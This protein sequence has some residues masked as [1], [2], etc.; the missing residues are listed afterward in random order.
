MLAHKTTIEYSTNNNNNSLTFLITGLKPDVA[1][2]RKKLLHSLSVHVTHQMNI[3]ASVRPS[4]LGK[5]GATLKD[6]TMRTLTSIQIP[7]YDPNTD[8]DDIDIVISITGDLEAIQLAKAE[9]DEIVAQKTKNHYVRILIDKSFH[10]FIAGPNKSQTNLLQLEYNIKIHIP[11]FDLDASVKGS[12]EI[13]LVGERLNVLNCQ[14]HILQLYADLQ[15]STRTVNLTVPKKQH[16]LVI[17]PKAVHLQEIL[18]KTGC[19][20]DIPTLADP[21][22]SIFIRGPEN[23]LSL[24]LQLVL[25]KAN[26][27]I[28]GEL[29]L[30]TVIPATLDAQLFARYMFTKE[31]HL[32]KQIETD[33]SCSIFQQSSVAGPIIEL[34]AKNQSNF[35][36]AKKSL[37]VL[38]REKSQSILI[39]VVDIPV[40]LH[41]FIVGKGGQNIVK[42]KSLPEWQNKLLDIIVPSENEEST[43]V[44]LIVSRAHG[45]SSDKEAFE[46]LERIRQHILDETALS[47]DFVSSTVK[48]DKKYHGRLIGTG[49]NALKELLAPYD[50][51]VS[52]RFPVLNNAD[53]N[54]DVDSVTVK[55]PKDNVKL[56]IDKI[57]TM[58]K[59]WTALDAII[60][61]TEVLSVP[62]GYGKKLVGGRDNGWII[63]QIK[64]LYTTKQLK[65]QPADTVFIKDLESNNGN[66]YLIFDINSDQTD[67]ITIKGP[68]SFLAATKK[69]LEAKL[70][71]LLDT[72]ELE[73]NIFNEMSTSAQAELSKMNTEMKSKLIKYLI[74]KEGKSLRKI[75]DDHQ[76]RVHFS[77]QDEH[78]VDEDTIGNVNI[79]GNKS[80]VQAVK[81]VFIQIIEEK[82]NNS[83]I[84]EMSVPKICLAQIVGRGG[85]N[86]A[87]LNET[88]KVRIDFGDDLDDDN[89]QCTIEG[90]EAGCLQV[91]AILNDII[92]DIAETDDF[93]IHIPY[94]LHRLVI[95]PGGSTI[96][97]VIEQFGGADKVRI[98]FPK[99]DAHQHSTAV[100]ITT[101][102]TDLE[103]IKKSLL[104]LVKQL[105]VGTS[106]KSKFVE[107]V[108]GNAD[109]VDHFSVPKNEA[110]FV[111]GRNLESLVEWMNVYGVSLWMDDATS[112]AVHIRILAKQ[113]LADQVS[114]LKLAISSKLRVTVVVPFPDDVM[115]VLIKKD[116]N[117]EVMIESIKGMIKKLSYGGV[118]VT[119]GANAFDGEH[120]GT[121]SIRGEKVKVDAVIKN[122]HKQFKELTK[123][124]FQ[125]RLSVPDDMSAHII[126]KRGATINRIRD[127]TKVVMDLQRSTGAESGM[128][129]MKA[130]NQ[131][132]IQKAVRMVKDI[133]EN[134][135]TIAKRES[136][137]VGF[138]NAR[139]DD[140]PAVKK[141]V[142]IP[143]IVPS[144]YAGRRQP[145]S[146]HKIASMVTVGGSDLNSSSQTLKV[147]QNEWQS[148]PIKSVKKEVD[149][150]KLNGHVVP[151]PVPV[152]GLSSASKKSKKVAVPVTGEV[153]DTH[154]VETTISAQPIL[155]DDSKLTIAKP[156]TPVV[157]NDSKLTISQSAT[158]SKPEPK[159]TVPVPASLQTKPATKVSQQTKPLAKA[160]SPV[161]PE[162]VVDEWQT[163]APGKKSSKFSTMETNSRTTA[164]QGIPVTV[165]SLSLISMDD[166]TTGSKKKKNKKKKSAAAVAAAAQA[167]V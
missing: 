93:V 101:R 43:D 157:V 91:E 160:P 53:K 167:D 108:H 137:E 60:N 165:S 8:T 102:A 4:L 14:Q 138:M 69:I 31:R 48:V 127:E 78:D 76:V 97:N 37:S 28:I 111:L 32:L 86:M 79:Y 80:G 21:S 145:G 94:Y 74:G 166:T 163:V 6:I 73:F 99:N 1:L 11:P 81:K 44:C 164:F 106:T 96:K 67:V 20:V 34:Q 112:D 158:I 152:V 143:G 126:G 129:V 51:S 16:R 130:S 35:D 84:V 155:I 148:I 57:K 147:K 39:G 41:K 18:A 83:F 24:A 46:L 25:E 65:L 124:P 71:Q 22:E 116:V 9:I 107:L 85:S 36:N 118:N 105:I 49:G 128:L 82:I 89:V 114:A 87:R 66:L 2:S 30:S 100:T 75:L 19:V 59:D 134:Q 98:N 149:E 135:E 26:S 142:G 54:I 55:G 17:G 120:P 133:L 154:P 27:V 113:S 103:A 15:Q 109:I 92:S 159:V 153:V 42:L 125:F 33:H 121:L 52:V 146:T 117:S 62:S 95:G 132:S 70:K 3:P 123:Y 139:I 136:E 58:V 110:N 29:T 161:E 40:G 115:S 12:D 144:G 119:A 47:A 63:K 88:Y 140:E 156:K 45:K 38:L 104:D 68:K 151:V 150:G 122:I 64:E 56:V 5:Q 61:F 50:D 77:K 10:Q 131:E 90:T 141:V 13:V 162:P 7:K 23:M 72:L